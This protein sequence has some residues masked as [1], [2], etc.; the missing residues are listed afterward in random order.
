MPTVVLDAYVLYPAAIR[1]FLLRLVEEEVFSGHMS[2]AILD[3]C[4]R[5]I[6]RNRP[7]LNP[8]MLL[9]SREAIEREFAHLIIDGHE[10]LIDGLE[11]PDRD[12]RHV[13]A[14]AI[15]RE[16]PMI[17]TFNTKDFPERALRPYGVVAMH[18][19]QFLLACV[20]KS[21]RT[22]LHVLQK[23]VSQLRN[24]PATMDQVLARLA[25]QGLP[26]T[27]AALRQLGGFDTP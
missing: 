5:S 20:E 18:P 26:E 17:V 23:Q 13:L 9:R 4:F 10:R 14:A 12:D 8:K 7:D 24:P 11:L 25:A 6:L 21:G 1:D 22:V 15:H 27:V 2:S 16:I 3:E 19:D